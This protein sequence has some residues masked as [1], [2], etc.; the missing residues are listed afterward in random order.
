MIYLL[1]SVLASTL[2]IVLFKLFETYNINTLQ[3]IVFNYY[4][5]FFCGIFLYDAPININSVTS[6]NW[7]YGAIALGFLFI[8]IFNLMALTAQRNGLSVA[9][10]A[11]KMSV[12]IP[13]IFGIVVYNEQTGLQKVSGII[14]ALIAVYLTTIKPN[15]KVNTRNGLLFPFLVFLGSGVIDSYIKYI[16][17]NYL[18]SNGI[19]IFSAS[20]FG[21][22]AI[23]GSLI[24]TYKIIQKHLKLNILSIIGGLILGLVNYGSI[25]FL[26]KALQNRSLE[27]SSIFTLNNVA[28][29]MFSTLIGMYLF[30]EKISTKNGIGIILAIL[31]IIL[32]TLS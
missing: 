27:S 8:I 24:L 19:P 22:A 32:V 3:A 23:I 21:C 10:V 11:A 16:E 13:I 12:I 7:F 26:I 2:I 6:S 17:T 30:K 28:I 15:S 14:L 20:I 5:A 1:L 31:S 29:V 18:E 25:H 9:S 4:S